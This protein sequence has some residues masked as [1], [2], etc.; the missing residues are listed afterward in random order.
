[1]IPF[2]PFEPDRSI[3]EP[4][5]SVNAVN[6]APRVDGWGPMPSAS[7]YTLALPDVY[8]GAISVRKTDGTYRTIAGTSSGLYELNMSTFDWDDISRT[9]GGVYS[10]PPGDDWSFEV[11]GTNLI[12][13]NL[14]DDIQVLDIE[15]GLN[16]AALGGTPPKA[17]YLWTAG[18]YLVAGHISGK[19]NQIRTSGINDA[20]FWTIG[21]RGADLQDFPDGEEIMGGI[22]SQQGAIIFQRTKI[23]SMTILPSGDYSF[24]TDVMN[25]SRGVIAPLSIAQIG[26]GQF[27]Y[28]SAD[29]FFMGA[30]A[31]PIGRERVDRWFSS[32]IDRTYISTIKA[33]VDPFEKIVWWT[34]QDVN[35]TLFRLGYSWALDRWCYADAVVTGMT[36]VVSP[37]IS[38]DN[39]DTYWAS[40]DAASEPFDSLRV[41]GGS[42]VLG[43]FDEDNKLGTATGPNIAATMDTADV[44]INP[45]RRTFL[46]E[47]HVNTDSDS[48]TLAAITSD[49]HGGTRTQGTPVSPYAATGICHFRSSARLHALRIAIPAGTVWNTVTGVDV[50]AR[51]EGR[52]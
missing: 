12:A 36:A 11:F 35:G 52:R 30:E 7:I 27:V 44:E 3:Y 6:V 31:V 18:D 4:S 10:V 20:T 41:T 50:V 28:Y 2:P 21:Q 15:A 49:K 5:A 24:R 14:A 19:P 37:G 29:G 38:F 22:G 48:F 1:M 45:G 8:K 26:P 47:G 23:R 9:S 16:F 39:A 51:P 42:P 34:A 40:F 13:A 43:I 32:T 17:K 25:P 33:M 46:Q